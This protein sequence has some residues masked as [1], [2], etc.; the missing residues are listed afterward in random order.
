[1]AYMAE[2]QGVLVNRSLQL[3]R[4]CDPRIA[5]LANKGRV[6]TQEAPVNQPTWTGRSGLSG[7]ANGM[8]TQRFGA[9]T[10]PRMAAQLSIAAELNGSSAASQVRT[11]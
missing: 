10:N 1:M 2:Q 11:T 4:K 3:M 8:H 7:S 9:T 6:Y 5:S